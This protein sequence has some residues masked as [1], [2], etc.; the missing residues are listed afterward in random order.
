MLKLVIVLSLVVT[1]S[2]VAQT[3]TPKLERW[4]RSASAGDHQLVWVYLTDKGDV[5]GRL[6]DGRRKLSSRALERRAKRGSGADVR[7]DDI[8][9]L[10]AYVQAVRER[11]QRVRHVSSRFNAPHAASN[12]IQKG[13]LG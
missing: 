1:Q 6:D 3:I 10:P 9:P 4:L 12:P 13:A 2:A 7:Y 11:A 5:S 8:P